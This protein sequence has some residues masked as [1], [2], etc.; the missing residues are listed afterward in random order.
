MILSDFL[1]STGSLSGSLSIN[2]CVFAV[3]IVSGA[4]DNVGHMQSKL[5]W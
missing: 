4:W 2:S 1:L 5:F 3:G